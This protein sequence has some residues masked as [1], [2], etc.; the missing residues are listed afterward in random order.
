MSQVV[1]YRRQR[2]P[3]VQVHRGF[4]LT[5]GKVP[6]VDSAIRMLGVFAVKM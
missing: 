3:A 4:E 2:E 5:S 6:G 1:R